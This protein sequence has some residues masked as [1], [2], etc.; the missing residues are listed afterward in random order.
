MSLDELLDLANRKG[1]V[2][3]L[4]ADELQLLEKL[5]KNL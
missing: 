3:K 4:S 2:S 5:S 1:G